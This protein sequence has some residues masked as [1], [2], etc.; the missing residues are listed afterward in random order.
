MGREVEKMKADICQG[1]TLNVVCYHDDTY[2]L[3]PN[4]LIVNTWIYIYISKQL[5]KK[6]HINNE[7]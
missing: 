1:R 7:F 3:N 4:Y 5:I 2:I 6:L